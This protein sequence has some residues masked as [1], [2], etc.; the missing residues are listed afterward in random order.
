MSISNQKNAPGEWT[1][2]MCLINKSSL[3]KWEKGIMK[4]V[5]FS[6]LQ[7]NSNSSAERWWILW[8]DTSRC[9]Y[10]VIGSPDTMA[11]GTCTLRTRYLL[12]GTEWVLLSG[13]LSVCGKTVT[14]SF[15]NDINPNAVTSVSVISEMTDSASQ[16]FLG[17]YWCFS[18]VW[19][20]VSH[21]Q[22]F[23]WRICQWYCELTCCALLAI[24]RFFFSTLVETSRFSVLTLVLLLNDKVVVDNKYVGLVWLSCWDT[25][26]W[27]IR[28]TRSAALALGALGCAHQHPAVQPVLIQ[29][30]TPIYS[31]P[32]GSGS[33]W[34]SA[35]GNTQ[36]ELTFTLWA[37]PVWESSQVL[38][39]NSEICVSHL[40]YFLDQKVSLPSHLVHKAHC[41]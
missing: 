8:W 23:S 25:S 36:D 18:E 5:R 38:C 33:C 30:L 6:V 21:S 27:S 40:V 39:Y 7:P 11:N 2:M 14:V 35:T 12:A 3:R 37:D 24:N 32:R 15:E 19:V 20:W 1:G 13:P 10:L 22:L 31:P 9:R 34:Y 26:C 41:C 29:N 28:T 16:G 4:C 17:T